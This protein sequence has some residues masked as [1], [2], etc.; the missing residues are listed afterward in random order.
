MIE[1]DGSVKENPYFE[2]IYSSGD[3][4][5]LEN[6]AYLP[7]G[8]LTDAQIVN[9][10]FAEEV[11]RFQF[12]NELMKAAAGTTQDCWNIITGYGLTILGEDVTLQSQNQT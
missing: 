6:N 10:D 7:L 11:N 2:D 5:L 3:I 4:H 1:R 8:F 9:V 12:Q